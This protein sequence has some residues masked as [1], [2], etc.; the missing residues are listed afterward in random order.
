VLSNIGS[1]YLRLSKFQEAIESYERAKLLNEKDSALR[2]YLGH[3]Y[4]RIGKYREAISEVSKAVELGNTSNEVQF[5]L[6]NLYLC[7]KN[8]ESALAQHAIVQRSNPEL[9]RKL[10]QAIY[11]DKLIILSLDEI[12]RK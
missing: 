3:A 5:F 12:A 2:V 1:I 4:A 7:A 11:S 8:K 9:A 10:Y 6:G